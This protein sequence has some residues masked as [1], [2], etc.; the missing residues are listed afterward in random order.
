MKKLY[1]IIC[2]KYR[3]FK[4]PKTLY[5]FEKKLVLSIIR[6]EFK[7]KDGKIFRQE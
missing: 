4:T 5:I 3:K 1:G 2:R 6:S 7:N